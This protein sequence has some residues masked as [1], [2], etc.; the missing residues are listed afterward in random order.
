MHRNFG[1]GL[2]AFLAVLLLA[3]SAAPEE[4]QAGRR[5]HGCCGVRGHYRHHRLRHH[6]CGGAY[7]G[8]ASVATSCCGSAPVDASCAGGMAVEGSVDSGEGLAPPPA[9]DV[10]PAPAP[11]DSGASPSDNPP[12]PPPGA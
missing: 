3:L 12:T 9:P 6:G 5:R 8:C 4:A 1:L 2:T 11:A 7:Q 10:P